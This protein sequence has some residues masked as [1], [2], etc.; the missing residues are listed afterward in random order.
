ME[1]EQITDLQAV[2]CHS[3]HIQH[4]QHHEHHQTPDKKNST[5]TRVTNSNVC[6]FSITHN[7]RIQDATCNS[8]QIQLKST[9]R[10]GSIKN[11]IQTKL[12]IHNGSNLNYV[13]K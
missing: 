12:Q 13:E 10:T 6:F 8:S 9:L 4:L 7:I 1:T 11:L 3:V 5:V 2:L